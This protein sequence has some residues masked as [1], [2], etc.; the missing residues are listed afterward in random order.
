MLQTFKTTVDFVQW[1]FGLV[2]GWL[3]TRK[4]VESWT[5]SVEAVEITPHRVRLYRETHTRDKT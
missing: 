2:K 1:A 4:S 3:P 5:H